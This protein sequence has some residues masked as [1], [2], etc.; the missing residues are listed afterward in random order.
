[1][2]YIHVQVG[3]LKADVKVAN[4]TAEYQA[5]R[6][7]Q[8]LSETPQQMQELKD[9]LWDLQT[10][11]FSNPTDDSALG[12][13]GQEH[14]TRLNELLDESE[15]KRVKDAEA[16]TAC[17][18]ELKTMQLQSQTTA[19][20]LR[21]ASQTAS[22]CASL[23]EQL[24]KSEAKFLEEKQAHISLQDK[25]RLLAQQSKSQS[26]GSLSPKKQR[27]LA[28]SGS[29]RNDERERA[30]ELNVRHLEDELGK[31]YNIYIYIYVFIAFLLL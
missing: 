10:R 6:V 2:L 13:L 9:K 5:N 30:L 27:E 15:L 23:Q 31:V 28:A 3:L 12:N 20:Q 8:Y 4:D 16:L 29:V 18:A 19:Q 14:I 1:M 24:R 17:Q 7:E 21:Y 22:L 11:A 26:K 25:H